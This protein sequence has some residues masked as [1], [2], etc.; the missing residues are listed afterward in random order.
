MTQDG[1]VQMRTP[2]N[3]RELASP[4]VRPLSD[5]PSI[6]AV[7]ERVGQVQGF[8]LGVFTMGV[9]WAAGRVWIDLKS[10]QETK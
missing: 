7:A 3:R 8:L 4:G 5:D 10:K 6:T 1:R 2:D 9:V